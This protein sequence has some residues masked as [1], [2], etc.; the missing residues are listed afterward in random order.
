MT[1]PP[2]NYR[3][4]VEPLDGP[5][6]LP[7]FSDFYRVGGQNDFTSTMLGG[8]SNPTTLSVAAGQG[9]AAH[10]ALLPPPPSKLN[11]DFIGFLSNSN[12]S[13]FIQFLPGLLYLPRGRSCFVVVIESSNSTDT[14]MN[15]S[16]PDRCWDPAK[17]ESFVKE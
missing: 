8:F 1:L 6:S 2:G 10:L 5:I 11:I 16:S 4:L 17:E 14:T 12:C 13:G 9:V 7:D 15:F 3:I